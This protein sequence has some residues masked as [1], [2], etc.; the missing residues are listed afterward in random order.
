ML[1]EAR[2]L[3]KRYGATAVLR[4]VSFSVR[5]GEILGL[6]GPNGAGKTTLF[7]C[8]AGL[9]VPDA[10]E[11][12]ISPAHGLF[13]VPDGIRPWQE[14]RTGEVLRFFGSLHGAAAVD[15]LADQ[16]QLRTLWRARVGT[17]S[18]GESKRLL[19]ALGLLASQRLLLLD[20][21]FDG[22]DFRQTR[23]VMSVLRAH[24]DGG[25]TLFLSIHQ[26]GDAARICDRFVLLSAGRVAGE[27]TL[28]ELRAR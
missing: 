22:L 14:Q 1:L 6:I 20:E 9:I 16:L 18:K 21:P 24:R 7:E 23:D 25:R 15:D 5:E 4:D 2:S 26:L 12:R 19:V 3:T 17:L 10:G 28:D 27:G 13:Y 8:L 11:V